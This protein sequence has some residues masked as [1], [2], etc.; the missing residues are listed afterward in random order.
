MLKIQTNLINIVLLC[1][2]PTDKKRKIKKKKKSFVPPA[3]EP[4]ESYSNEEYR[5]YEILKMGFYIL[6]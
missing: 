2:W 1:F 6:G 3:S 4:T 5:H